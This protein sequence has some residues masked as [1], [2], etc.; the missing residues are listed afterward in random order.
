MKMIITTPYYFPKIGG[1]E[2]YARQLGIALKELQTWDVI[3]IT[4]NEHSN[5]T[6]VGMEDGMKVYRLPIL[7][8]LF[9]TPVNPFWYFSLRGIFK[10]ERPDILLAHTPVPTMADATGLAKGKIPLILFYHAATLKKSGSFLFN[11]IAF[12]YGIYERI[13]LGKAD[14][15]AAVSS[16]VKE[17]MTASVKDKTIIV[18]NSVWQSEVHT[19]IQPAQPQHFLFI[20]SLDK[21]HAWK[22]LDLILEAISHAKQT[23]GD[24][25]HLTVM[26]DGDH[27]AVYKETVTRCGIGA[28][29]TFTGSLTG[30][31]KEK[32]L[33]NASALLCYPT[34]SNDAFPTVIL[35]AWSRS[36]PVI[37][38]AI[39]PI[40]FII[41][42]T[43]DGFL[44]AP[45]DAI[46]L[47][48]A[49]HDFSFLNTETKESIAATAREKVLANYTWER[50]SSYVDSI[51]KGLL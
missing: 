12:A 13:T 15:V 9:N 5:K 38:S 11:A 10:K 27:L 51:A 3:I 43:Q 26:G 20:S 48:K 21:T 18:P 14:V 23:Y 40:P 46:A 35:E 2:N 50:Q 41:D 39:G 6:I 42:D 16:Y 1:L 36:V 19:R 7:F 8:K 49:L 4:T 37:A 32:E 33:Q 45:N 25:I 47:S 30:D 29:V 44:V 28:S 17:Q 22:G 34:T 31:A 24:D